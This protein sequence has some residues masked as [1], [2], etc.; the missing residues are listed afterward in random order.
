THEIEEP[1]R[2][3]ELLK[4]PKVGA[5]ALVNAVGGAPDGVQD[6]SVLA[7][8]EV[9]L[10]YEGYVMRERERAGRLR[11]QAEVALHDDLPYRD[12][13]TLSFEAREKLARVRP[14]TL[15]QAGRIPG[16]SPSDLQ[17]LLLEVRRRRAA[18][19]A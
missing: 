2:A 17:N 12:F 4:R 11:K 5:R 14:G 16:V 1:R 3:I 7:A 8:V 19:S 10:K 9:E 15:A 13:E 18:T 6:D